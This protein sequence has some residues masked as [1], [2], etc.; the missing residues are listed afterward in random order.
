M[1]L[2]RTHEN[3][4]IARHYRHA[5]AVGRI[6]RMNAA[7]QSACFRTEAWLAGH[8]ERILLRDTDALEIA[9]ALLLASTTRAL[10]RASSELTESMPLRQPAPSKTLRATAGSVHR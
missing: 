10:Y 4:W 5:P 9:F 1:L 7:G 3:R 6:T 2:R 8:D